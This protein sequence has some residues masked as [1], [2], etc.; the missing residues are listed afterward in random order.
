[1]E[2]ETAY[3]LGILCTEKLKFSTNEAIISVH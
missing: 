1:M 3:T 2:M